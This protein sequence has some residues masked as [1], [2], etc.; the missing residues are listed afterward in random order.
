MIRQLFVLTGLVIGQAAH[1]QQPVGPLTRIVSGINLKAFESHFRYLSD[2]LMEGRGPGT[3]GGRLAA[4]YIATQFE[5]MGLR[6]AG[7]DSGWF[8]PF[9]LKADQVVRSELTAGSEQFAPGDDQALLLWGGDT[10]QEYRG[11]AVFVGYGIVSPENHWDDYADAD[12]RGK[13]VIALAGNPGQV[14]STLFKSASN[15]NRI[16]KTQEALRHGA[17]GVLVIHSRAATGYPW[18]N[19]SRGWFHES[20]ALLEPDRRPRGISGWIRDSAAARLLR[21]AG[22]DLSTLMISSARANHRALPVNLDLSVA[23]STRVRT[24]QGRNVLGLWPGQGPTAGQIVVLG[25]HYDH[26]GIGSPVNG[27][28]IYNGTE[29][30]ANGIAALLVTAE[31]FA[32]SGVVP[33]RSVLFI[34][35]DAEE[36]GLLGSQ[37]YV[38]APIFPLASTVAM[39]NL[40]GINVYA[41]TSDTYALGLDYSSLGTV[42]RN[43]ARVEGLTVGIS[44]DEEKFLEDQHFFNRSD[45]FSFADAGVPS[46]FVWGGYK[47]IGKPAGWMQ[48]KLNEYLSTRYHQPAD[49]MQDWYSFEGSAA[50][51]RVLARTL[52][53]VAMAPRF[54]AWNPDSP[55]QRK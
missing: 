10:V 46:L 7:Q 17:I 36:E 52:Y 13:L 11:P 16:A 26:L 54:P 21:L 44:A 1:A 37:A 38:R 43:A 32:R 30:N 33:R 6:P 3:R 45:H 25:G 12:V 15:S 5:R 49:E 24:I 22:L 14:D 23:T 48:Q 34:A 18:G 8:Q 53:A 31:A 19:I 2:D 35:F 42:F 51:L 47:A 40:D 20:I 41:K 27:D 55:F 28:S 50:D 39:L 4:N 29:D 9:T